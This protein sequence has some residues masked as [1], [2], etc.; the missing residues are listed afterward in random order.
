MAYALVGVGVGAGSVNN[1][2]VTTAA[3]DTAGADLIVAVVSDFSAGSRAVVTDSKSNTWTGLTSSQSGTNGRNTIWWTSP[4][5]VGSGHTFTATGTNTSP[6]INVLAF[7]GSV[8]SPFDVENGAVQAFGST[9]ATGT[10]TPSKT[11]EVLIA[12]FTSD[13][14]AGSLA[15][16]GGFVITTQVTVAG[17][18]ERGAL[19]YLIQTSPAPANPTWSWSPNAVCA[20]RIATFKALGGTSGSASSSGRM[21]MAFQK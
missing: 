20:A 18:H 5:S 4:T 1:S 13:A 19:A 12:G 17:T 10:V 11:D 8:A 21:F 2:N 3:Y 14:A 15:I 16:N 6:T 9:L 7:S